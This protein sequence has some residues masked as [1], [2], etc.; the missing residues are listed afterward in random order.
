MRSSASDTEFVSAESACRVL[1]LDWDAEID[2][3]LS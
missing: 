3:S 1:E 2:P